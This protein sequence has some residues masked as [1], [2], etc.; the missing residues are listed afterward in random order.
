M[1]YDLNLT[2]YV[3]CYFPAFLAG[4]CVGGA[5]IT[6]A[7]ICSRVIRRLQKPK[8]YTLR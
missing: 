2:D 6:L 7:P 5:I 3:I 1:N 8:I 4:F